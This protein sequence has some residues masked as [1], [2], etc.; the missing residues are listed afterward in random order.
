MKNAN[1][2]PAARAKASPIMAAPTT[3]PVPQYGVRPVAGPP[4]G[5]WPAASRP[6][7][8]GA[9][10]SLMA[11]VSAELAG[12]RDLGRAPACSR[13]WAGPTR[14]TDFAGLPDAVHESIASY[15]EPGDLARLA[16]TNRD[17]RR[18]LQPKATR[19]RVLVQYAPL[20][21][22]PACIGVMLAAAGPLKDSPALMA[23][24]LT[25]MGQELA[26]TPPDLRGQSCRELL[27][28]I[29]ALP[30][31]NRGEPLRTMATQIALLPTAEREATFET[32]LRLAGPAAPEALAAVLEALA[33]CVRP[34]PTEARL[35]CFQRLLNVAMEH[36]P[37][38]MAALLAPVIA[39][40]PRDARPAAFHELQ[41]SAAKL[42]PREHEATLPCWP[43]T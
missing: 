6:T 34:L 30:A 29:E 27:R 28:A 39:Q 20:V 33:D 4:A 31:R 32:V 42:P 23:A 24:P 8:C 7:S 43:G 5:A 36:L 13:A 26:R 37:G 18:T 9:A 35:R 1:A 3:L 12:L 2:E 38:R 22:D 21:R 25:L 19:H 16:S 14:P 10:Q 15:L 17:L 41:Q 40:L 11:S